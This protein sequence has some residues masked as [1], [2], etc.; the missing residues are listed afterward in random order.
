MR[1]GSL[2]TIGRICV[3][4]NLDQSFL[5][6]NVISAISKNVLVNEAR[7]EA[8]LASKDWEVVRNDQITSEEGWSRNGDKND[9]L[10]LAGI[11][12]FT[13]IQLLHSLNPT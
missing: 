8:M 7:P 9:A 11:S 13:S 12:R 1:H 6:E 3:K 2:P 4:L 5:D 10:Q